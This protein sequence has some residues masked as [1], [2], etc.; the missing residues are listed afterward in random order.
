[1]NQGLAGGRGQRYYVVKELVG[2]DVYWRIYCKT[3][4][5]DGTQGKKILKTQKIKYY[6][7]WNN[8]EADLPEAYYLDITATLKMAGFIR[9]KAH[10]DWIT[11]KKASEWWHFHYNKNLQA[12]FQDEMELLG[13]NEATLRK[14]GWD[15]D[16]KLD[17]KPG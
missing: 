11:N 12:T 4:L 17:K 9:I 5:Q 10:S 13:Y 7:F 14:N 15:T 8:T 2:A 6:I 3:D 16:L 1:M